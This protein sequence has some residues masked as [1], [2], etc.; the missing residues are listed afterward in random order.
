M[1]DRLE[2]SLGELDDCWNRIGVWS[3][4]AANCP[5]LQHCVHCRNCAHYAAAGRQMLERTVPADY[6]DEWTKR[7][8]QPKQAAETRSDSA[9]LFRLGDEWLAIDSR[10]VSEVAKMHQ[11]HSIPHRSDTLVKGLVN[12]RGTLKLCVSL[13]SILHLGKGCEPHT[14]DHEILERM[15]LIEDDDH[16]FVFPVSEVE[17]IIHYAN[18]QV[19]ALPATLAQARSK[20]T[21]GILRWNEQH[22][23]LLDRDLLFYALARGLT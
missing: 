1:T 23:G 8:A 14:T 3:S 22:V 11:I 19:R 18:Q 4:R 9:L 10:C 17:G 6:R 12:I 21:T 13:G 16:S 7:F 5:E 15:I 20:L 2:M